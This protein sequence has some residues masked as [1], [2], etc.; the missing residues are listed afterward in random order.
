M[1]PN[2]TQQ[3]RRDDTQELPLT[4]AIK[5]TRRV[6][7][8]ILGGALIVA[9]LLLI[10][11]PGPFTLP[12]LFAGLTVLSWEF[13]WA[14]RTLFQVRRRFAAIKARRANRSRS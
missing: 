9:G 12:L 13:K 3:F 4:V 7:I 10:P 6:A 8:G 2:D 11:L 1:G 14:K 5:H